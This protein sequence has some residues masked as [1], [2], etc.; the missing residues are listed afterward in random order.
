MEITGI[1]WNGLEKLTWMKELLD[2]IRK[3]GLD[4]K[5]AGLH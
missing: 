1:D 3:S 2:W 4:G 5:K